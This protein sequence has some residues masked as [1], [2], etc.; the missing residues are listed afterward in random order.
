MFAPAQVGAINIV[1]V[2][3]STFTF[4][5]N[6]PTIPASPL[7]TFGGGT[8]GNNFPA[9]M[10][11]PTLYFRNA[12]LDSSGTSI[13]LAFAPVSEF[14][15]E[16]PPSPVSLSLAGYNNTV[17]NPPSQLVPAQTAPACRAVKADRSQSVLHLAN[18]D[19]KTTT[20][21]D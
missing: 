6:I 10:P 3:D 9:S 2:T 17:F 8:S 18:V 12:V 11:P 13:G 7:V 4:G 16:S 15:D 21:A 20:Q 5:T 1:S 19:R 14:V